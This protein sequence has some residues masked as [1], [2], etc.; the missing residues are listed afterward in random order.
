VPIDSNAPWLSVVTVS[1]HDD[2]DLASTIDSVN[3][4]DTAGVEHL[5]VLADAVASEEHPSPAAGRRRVIHRPP[6]GVYAAMNAGLAE[7]TGR[8]V[9]FLN[10]GDTY[11]SDDV[12][13]R[14]HSLDER[15]GFE[16]AFGRLLVTRD[17]VDAGRVRGHTISEIRAHHFRG[18]YFPEHPTVFAERAV[19]TEL[20]GFD[21]SFR[22][23]A[24]YRLLIEL[25][26]TREGVDL[27]FAVTR[28]SLGGVSD[29]RWAN[30]VLECHRARMQ[31]FQ[32]RGMPAWRE[33][34]G[35]AL[36][37]GNQGL[38]RVARIALPRRP[39]GGQE[40]NE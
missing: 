5:I 26:T 38:R 3:R 23:A 8:L 30:S 27:G 20:G 40:A 29:A 19:L 28:Y 16:W 33:R 31:Y 32:P 14:V 34:T 7:S 35:T 18:M 25:A 4:Q 11:A 37:L 36:E 12:L 9:H 17:A 13:A 24:D 22:T 10:A 1:L 21:T 39:A 6:D 2:A 15:K